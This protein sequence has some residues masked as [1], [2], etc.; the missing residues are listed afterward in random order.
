[1]CFV[2]IDI[3]KN[4]FPYYVRNSK[5][6]KILSSSALVAFVGIDSRAEES[7]QMKKG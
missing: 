7:G 1:M 3:S 5:R 2:G 4:S 6:I